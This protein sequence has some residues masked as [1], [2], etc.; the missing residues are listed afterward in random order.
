MIISIIVCM[1]QNNAIGYK[2][3]LLYHIAND[4]QRFKK[5]TT[6]HCII[7]GK[8]T[9]DSLPKGAL[10]NRKNIIIS[11][12]SLEIEGCEIYNSIEKALEACQKEEEVFIIGGASIYQQTLLLADRIY[13]TIV[14]NTPTEADSYFPAIDSKE[15]Q[16]EHKEEFYDSPLPYKFLTL[17]RIP[18][19][20]HQYPSKIIGD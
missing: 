6:N 19:H 1:A 11:H 8:K 2:N 14:E 12:H 17:H 13:L 15:W 5:L 4:M 9:F 16:V 20:Q 10:P 3:G 18:H 7:M